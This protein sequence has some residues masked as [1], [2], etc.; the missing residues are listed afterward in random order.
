MR[1]PL[2]WL[3]DYVDPGLPAQELADVLTMGGLEVEAILRPTGGTRGVRVVEVA[4]AERIAGSDHLTLVQA[5]DGPRTYE[6]VCGA[7][8]FTVGDRVPAALPGATLPGGVRVDRRTVFGHTSHGMLAS[9]R[10][11]GVGDDH[12]GIWVLERDAPLGSELADWLDLDD[13]VLDIAVTPDRGYALS[14]LGVARD[15][16]ALTGADLHAPGD[17]PAE[18][19]GG[20]VGVPVT[21]A[22]PDR[23]R[24]FDARRVEGLRV[25]PSPA[26]LQRRLAATGA[27]PISNVVDAT[28]H[29]LLETGH[30][31][32]AYDLALLAGPRIDVRDAAPGESLVTLDGVERALDSDVLV[33]ADAYGPDGLPRGRG[34]A[35]SVGGAR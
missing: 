21:I 33:R 28:N 19:I 31:V 15:V 2:S 35:R 24:R 22:D 12:R 20:G 32:H 8:N 27:R 1:V 23:C 4:S 11:L 16:A 3:R 13:P 17:A 34:R 7:H 14:V 9:P 25:G 6:I 29:A 5:T 10:E 30:P 26:W 18:G